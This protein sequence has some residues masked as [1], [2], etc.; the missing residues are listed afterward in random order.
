MGNVK[1][2]AHVR[3]F[4]EDLAAVRDEYAQI[5]KLNDSIKELDAETRAITSQDT[6]DD[7]DYGELKSIQKKREML[8]KEIA[9]VVTAIVQRLLPQISAYRRYIPR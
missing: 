3:K 4:D 9:R 6:G 7:V 8:D 2:A 5:N 1:R